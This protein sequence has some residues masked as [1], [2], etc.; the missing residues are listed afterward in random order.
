M[1]TAARFGGFVA[2]YFNATGV[3]YD[4]AKSAKRSVLGTASFTSWSS[5]LYG[6][7]LSVG[8]ATTVAVNAFG[9]AFRNSVNSCPVPSKPGKSTKRLR[10]NSSSSKGMNIC[11]IN[12]HEFPCH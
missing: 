1:I 5:P 2:A 3:E 7:N 4:S 12:G 10:A 6:I 8:Y 11:Q 9:R